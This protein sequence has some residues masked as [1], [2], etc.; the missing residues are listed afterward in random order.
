[1]SCGPRTGLCHRPR[2]QPSGVWNVK[3]CA[4]GTPFFS[5]VGQSVSPAWCVRL[6]GVWLF[7]GLTLSGAPRAF[8]PLRSLRLAPRPPPVCL[9]P[10]SHAPCPLRASLSS[11]FQR[12]LPTSLHFLTLESRVEKTP[13]SQESLCT[14]G[15][16]LGAARCGRGPRL[17]PLTH[18]RPGSPWDFCTAP[19]G[20][21]LIYLR[22]WPGQALGL[23]FPVKLT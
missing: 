14:P 7:P 17:A 16:S 11:S 10:S 8:P 21:S 22:P 5:F 15:T 3:A 4:S 23:T 12:L 13:I 2:E 6:S 20:D 18:R 1:M 9:R 19:G